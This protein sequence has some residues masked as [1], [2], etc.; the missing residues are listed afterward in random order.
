VSDQ[1]SLTK[2]CIVCKGQASESTSITILG[3]DAFLY[4]C[5]SCEA[6]YFPDPDWL[7]TAYT[8]AI[9][10]LDTG[11]VERCVDIANVLT[12]F[13]WRQSGVTAVD[14]G[15]GIGLLAR[16]MRDRGFEFTS[17]DPMAGYVLPLPQRGD[18]DVDVIT[19]IEVLEHLTDPVE[20]LQHCISNCDL[21]FIS[22]H[23]IPKA[24]LTPDWHY[25]QPN[26]GQHIFFCSEVTLE[27]IASSLGVMLTS[28]GDNL[29][30][31]HRKPLTFLQRCVIRYQRMAWLVGHLSAIFTRGRGLA[32]T[33]AENT[34]QQ[35]TD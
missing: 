27:T 2:P 34:E 28:N 33:D 18:I 29:H 12:P 3:R 1:V 22:T 7:E 8:E 21:I 11:I 16:L 25:L 4:Q 26:T 10:S 15:G 6:T 20:T 23:L 24:G 17:W 19:M 31:L 30:V 32:D 5:T 14:F 9:S 13:L 35:Q